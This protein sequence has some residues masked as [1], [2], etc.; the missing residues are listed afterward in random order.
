MGRR[1]KNNLELPK[2]V[3]P[4]RSKGRAYWY[5]Q[6][7]RGTAG[8]AKCIRIFGDPTAPVG[9]PENE[10]FWRELNY[11]VSQ[12]IVYPAGSIK[13]LVDQYR[14]DDAFKRLAPRTQTVY[15]LHLN[16]LSK[17]DVWGML[18]AKL[19]TA[20][21]VKA[22]RDA[23]SQTPGMANQMLS[24]GRT[25][26]AWAI[27]MGLVN[28]NPFENVGP[29]EIPDRGHVPWPQWALEEV[30]AS[31]P[32]DLRRMVR[33]GVMTCQRESDLIR[34]GPIHHESLRGRGSGIWCR[35]KKTRRRRRSVF[36]PLATA[37][38]LELDRWGE[39]PITFHN[40]R[41]KAP[42]ERHNPDR[43]FYS[44]RGAT[45]SET[46][47]R[48]RW[49]R[50]LN[51]SGEG[52]AV[53]KKWKEWLRQQIARYEWEID[54]DDAKGPTIHGLRGTGVLLRWAEGFDV[55]QISND[56][57]MSRQ[58]VEHYMRFRDQM[59]IAASGRDRLRIVKG[60]G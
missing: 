46:S 48:A 1:R 45:Y 42:I 3:F 2:G 56:I 60:E 27:P 13:T 58:M 4:V 37:D 53:C 20:P 54:P 44:P 29:L 36:I 15:N 24:V 38:A 39:T 14:E 50:W 9:T 25:L 11:V 40:T 31:V 12:T 33:L 47:L 34:M 59:G 35:P 22:A 18:P 52:E 10:Q 32:E 5:Y 49:H 6:P 26:Y 51:T 7:G 19:L 41:W 17:P 57:G 8:A 21:A 55:D 28:N 30:L 16:R 23:L 43:Y